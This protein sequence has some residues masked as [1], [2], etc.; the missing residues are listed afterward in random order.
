MKERLQKI[1]ANA[2]IASR[3]HAEKMITTGR[4]SVNHEIVTQLGAKA[5]AEK[6]VIHIDG[7]L[8]TT[9]NTKYYI[10]LNKPPGYVTTLHD[11]QGRHTVLD[12]VKGIP[13]RVYPVG[14]LDY[15][16]GGLLLM[17][18]DGY[19]A[20]HIQHPRFKKTKTYQIKIQGHLSKEELKKLE[21]GI[22]LED[23][24]FKP[25]NIRVEKINAKSCWLSLTLQEGKN[26]EIRRGLE[27][28]G[29]RVAVLTRE[30][31][32]EVTLNGM[33]E[34]SWRYLTDKEVKMLIGHAGKKSKIKKS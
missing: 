12:L 19:F 31:I 21:K 20:Q 6:D 29:H 28:I 34:G 33:E 16:S 10:A 18:N 5:D 32:G 24:L 30:S 14:R 4:V 9:A 8:I 22:P 25:E 3:R 13:E 27:K 17:T 1:I 7:R 15:H 2:G 23:G 11:P 26:R